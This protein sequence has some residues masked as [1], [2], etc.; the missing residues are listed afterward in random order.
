MP[1]NSVP[2]ENMAHI[3]APHPKCCFKVNLSAAE[4]A[5]RSKKSSGAGAASQ[6]VHVL[7]TIEMEP[8]PLPLLGGYGAGR[9]ALVVRANRS[10]VP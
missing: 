4:E 7:C 2:P 8:R 3:S 9:H 1:P 10:L 6:S 5:T